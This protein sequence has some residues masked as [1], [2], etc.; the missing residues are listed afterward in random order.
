M[1]ITL[2][3]RLILQGTVDN[4]GLDHLAGTKALDPNYCRQPTLWLHDLCLEFLTVHSTELSLFRAKAF[5][6][7]HT[8]NVAHLTITSIGIKLLI[9]LAKTQFKVTSVEPITF[10][11]PSKYATGAGFYLNIVPV[12]IKHASTIITW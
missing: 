6:H 11:T 3:K 7:T 10:P 5:H 8:I 1:I 12:T 9:S 2:Y 4:L